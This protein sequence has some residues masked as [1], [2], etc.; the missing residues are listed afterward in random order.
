MSVGLPKKE[1]RGHRVFG[2]TSNGFVQKDECGCR[3]AIV[4]VPSAT[5]IHGDREE[6]SSWTS[7]VYNVERRFRGSPKTTESGRCYYLSHSYL[8]GLRSQAES[9]FLR[10]RTRRAQ[11]G[12]ERVVD[13]AHRIQIVLQLVIRKWLDDHPCAVFA[14][15]FPDVHRRSD[16]SAHVVQTVEYSH[17]II[18]LPRIFLGFGHLER[19]SVG[20]AVMFG[21]IASCFDRFIVVVESE[22]PRLGIRFRHQNR[23]TAFPAAHVRHPRACFQLLL[24]VVECRDP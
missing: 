5:P 13:T 4:T 18:V 11:Q 8:A 15:R 3:N 10:S 17:E 9:Y 12:R 1:S 2:P 22:E 20:D 23:G 14:Q 7:F 6:I 24:H 21:S 19:D 16:W